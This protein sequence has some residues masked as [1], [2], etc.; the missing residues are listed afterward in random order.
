MQSGTGTMSE[1]FQKVTIGSLPATAAK[2]WGDREALYFEGRR[3]SFA[4][5]DKLVDEVAKGLIALGVAHGDHVAIWMTNRPEILA[6]LYAVPKIGAVLVPLNTRYR[7]K[8]ISYTINQSDSVALISMDRS[9]PVDYLGMLREAMPD[10]AASGEPVS[11]SLANFPKLKRVVLTGREI[12]PGTLHWD[13]MIAHGHAIDDAALQARAN[14]VDPDDVFI[15]AYTSGTTGDPKGVMHGHICIRNIAERAQ[16]LGIT[17]NDVHLC[18][19]PLFHAYGL[20]EIAFSA[21]LTGAKQVMTESFDAGEVLRLLEQERG[22]LIHGFDTHYADLVAAQR[23]TPRDL[24]SLRL[25]TFPSGMDSSIPFSLSAQREL[26]PTVSGWG[27]TE[28]WAFV[29]VSSPTATEEQRVYASGYPMHGE[30][31]RVIDQDTGADM[32]TGEPGELLCRGYMN[33]RGYYKNPDATAETIDAEGWVH[34]GDMA[35]LRADGHIRFMGRYKD[36]LKVGG[37]NMAPAE[38]EAYLSARFDIAL[39]A[40]VGYPDPRLAEVPVAFIVRDGDAAIT[41]HDIIDACRGKL[42]SYKIPR[43][44][45]F[46]DTIPMTSSGK[47]QKFK[48]R[49][50]ALDMLGDPRQHASD[51]GT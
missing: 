24:S 35:A 19:L 41:E 15:I 20:S 44:V 46:V 25:G 5:F 4:E 49:A 30:E 22:T 23:E 10:T 38:L 45:L 16:L 33:T 7:T 14:A 27:M 6:L 37:E 47:I 32:P 18:Y 26:C 51:Q 40:V 3:W 39:I 2:R 31:F 34:T 11:L 12:L 43:H 36:M 17:A 21:V 9:G 29:T 13:D 1:W 48:L 42:A 28:S 8:D 50:Q